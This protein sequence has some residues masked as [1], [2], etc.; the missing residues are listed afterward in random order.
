[1]QNVQKKINFTITIFK[2]SKKKKS[3]FNNI[4]NT[5]NIIFNKKNTSIVIH[6]NKNSI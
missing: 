5:S 6:N 2:I 1:M 4:C 3:K